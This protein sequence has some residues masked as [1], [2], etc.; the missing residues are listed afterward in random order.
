MKCSILLGKCRLSTGSRSLFPSRQRHCTWW[1]VLKRFRLQYSPSA[2]NRQ[3]EFLIEMMRTWNLRN[4]RLLQSLYVTS[5]PTRPP[6]GLDIANITTVNGET[7]HHLENSKHQ[8]FHE[9]H[10]AAA[11]RPHFID[12]IESGHWIER[13]FWED[14]DGRVF[15]NCFTLLL[16]EEMQVGA[17]DC[18]RTSMSFTFDFTSMM[19][20][21][22]PL[23]RMIPSSIQRD[24]D[25]VLQLPWCIILFAFVT[26]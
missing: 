4:S 25:V 17:T 24:S 15:F 21:R 1:R 2:Q 16:N 11:W 12:V 10:D 3:W 22:Q 9:Y 18:I 6:K 20:F 13:T 26:A 8:F 5:S 14:D 7:I 19:G 23:V